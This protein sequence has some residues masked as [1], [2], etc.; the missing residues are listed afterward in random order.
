MISLRYVFSTYPKS[1]NVRFLPTPRNRLPRVRSC[2][3]CTLYN[4]AEFFFIQ[5]L[6]LFI[7]SPSRVHLFTSIPVSGK[8]PSN[9]NTDSANL[10]KQIKITHQ[11]T[12]PKACKMKTYTLEIIAELINALEKSMQNYE[13]NKSCVTIDS[14]RCCCERFY[15]FPSTCFCFS[16][17]YLC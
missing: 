10:D 6:L 17:N 12:T 1:W 13:F 3:Q 14:S 7:F 15:Q 16:S 5:K 2:T 4:E 8:S 11:T 9:N